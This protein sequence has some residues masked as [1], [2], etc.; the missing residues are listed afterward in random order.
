[1]KKIMSLVIAVLF[2]FGMSAVSFAADTAANAPAP[3]KMEKKAPAKKKATK[4]K[5]TKKKATKTE[6]KT[7]TTPAPAK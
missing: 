4:K 1:M 6:E 2:A 7:E 3:E 5:A